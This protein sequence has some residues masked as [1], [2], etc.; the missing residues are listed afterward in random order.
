MLHC[1]ILKKKYIEYYYPNA[2]YLGLNCYNDLKVNKNW[3]TL[4]KI[5]IT[6]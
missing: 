2:F 1:S 5:I 4:Y 6:I 3:H